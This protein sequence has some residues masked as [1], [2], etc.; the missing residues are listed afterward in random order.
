MCAGGGGGTRARSPDMWGAPLR[1]RC[2]LS[3]L[4]LMV[5]VTVVFTRDSVPLDDQEKLPFT[6][7]HEREIPLKCEYLQGQSTPWGL[8]SAQHWVKGGAW[9]SHRGS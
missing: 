8:R 1:A 9:L 3:Q 4:R 5:P 7:V 2:S 6:I